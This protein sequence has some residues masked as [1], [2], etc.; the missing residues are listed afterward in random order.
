M[1]EDQYI[2][3]RASRHDHYLERLC[4]F[5]NAQGGV[6]EIGRNDNAKVPGLVNASQLMEESPDKIPD[7]LAV[8]VDMNLLEEDGRQ[9]WRITVEPYSVPI[10]YSGEF[11]DRSGSTKQVLKA[12]ALDHFLL[13][14]TG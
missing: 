6:L 2:E 13:N 1:S 9:Y 8:R 12:I 5:A 4:G 7:L 14:E 11:H 10:S 3:F